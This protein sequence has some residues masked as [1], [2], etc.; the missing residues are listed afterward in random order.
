MGN[1]I[2]RY[3]SMFGVVNIIIALFLILIFFLPFLA[4]VLGGWVGV[5]SIKNNL[6]GNFLYYLWRLS[7]AVIFISSFSL[8]NSGVLISRLDQKGRKGAI[9]SCI[10]IIIGLIL[11]FVSET[12]ELTLLNVAPVVSSDLVNLALIIATMFILYIE[13]I[14]LSSKS[15]Q[16]IFNDEK[17]YISFRRKIIIIGLSYISPMILSLIDRLLYIGQNYLWRS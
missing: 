2:R 7:I 1:S 11:N 9:C 16:R 12:V 10:F 8:F 17:I 13:V 15:V 14:Y 4:S 3:I 5:V 6:H